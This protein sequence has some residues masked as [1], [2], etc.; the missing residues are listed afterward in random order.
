MQQPKAQQGS[1]SQRKDDESTE[2]K[3]QKSPLTC[4]VMGIFRKR[5]PV[6]SAHNIHSYFQESFG[7]NFP[8]PIITQ[9]WDV[10]KEQVVCVSGIC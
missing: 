1:S 6:A 7:S 8:D 9:A 3:A 5:P 10:K 2:V 4:Q